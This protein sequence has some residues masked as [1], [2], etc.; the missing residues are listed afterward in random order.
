MTKAQVPPEELYE[1]AEI[2]VG[3]DGIKAMAKRFRVRK[4][5]VIFAVWVIAKDSVW[6]KLAFDVKEKKRQKD[7]IRK[8]FEGGEFSPSAI[9]SIKARED[10]RQQKIAEEKR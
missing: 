6:A 10:D 2:K 4:E 7:K 1:E 8:R 3:D 5:D 9:E